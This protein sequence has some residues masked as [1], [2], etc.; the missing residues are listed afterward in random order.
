MGH[1]RRAQNLGKGDPTSLRGRRITMVSTFFSVR[2][3]RRRK[4]VSLTVH[5]DVEKQ[6]VLRG[7]GLPYGLK[8]SVHGTVPKDQISCS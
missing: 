4:D 7:N 8:T 1:N 5:V 6:W 3:F 2:T